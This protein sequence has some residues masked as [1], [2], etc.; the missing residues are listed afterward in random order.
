MISSYELHSNT[1]KVIGEKLRRTDVVTEALD[2]V[3]FKEAVKRMDRELKDR[4]D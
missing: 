4:E 2:T 1:W 3:V